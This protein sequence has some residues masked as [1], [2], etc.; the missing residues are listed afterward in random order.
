VSGAARLTFAVSVRETD[1]R[2]KSS[3][4]LY[5]ISFKAGRPDKCRRTITSP[6]IPIPTNSTFYVFHPPDKSGSR[7]TSL[8]RGLEKAF[9]RFQQ[10]EA[11]EQR[12]KCGWTSLESSGIGESTERISIP[13]AVTKYLAEI[14]ERGLS[15]VSRRRHECA[16]ED[17]RVSCR[18][19][20]VDEI[21]R[22]DIIFYLSWMKQKMRNNR[23]GQ[24]NIALRGRLLLLDAFLRQYGRA[25]LL[26]RKEWPAA[27]KTKPSVYSK[28]KWAA[29][30]DATIPRKGDSDEL[31]ARKAEERIRLEF[32]RYSACR[33]IEAATAE[34]DDID[35]GTCLFY[36]R[37]KPR[38]NWRPKRLVE[39]QIVLPAD[40]VKRLFAR[41]DAKN[42]TGLLFP[43][44]VGKIDNNLTGFLKSAAKRARITER[45]T[46][47]KIRRTTAIEY[48]SRFGVGNC[49][50]LLGCRSI[51]MTARYVSTEDMTSPSRRAE[52]EEFFSTL[53]AR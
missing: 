11:N 46:L 2:G 7:V 22:D 26:S 23:L 25:K 40:F 51:A 34:Y 18:K 13:D 32:L 20:F 24:P 38:L 33:D 16:L 42:C 14:A 4:P 49:L 44:T 12:R 31:I 41:R 50:R 43:N 37:R 6:E 15:E 1:E 36:I 29:I 39:R 53:V 27:V 8:G 47:P 17:F 19:T 52:L 9:L 21:A 5:K 45:V 10:F 28:Q 35:A 48:T 30:M 3:Y